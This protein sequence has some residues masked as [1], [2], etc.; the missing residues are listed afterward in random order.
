MAEKQK[1]DRRTFLTGAGAAAMAFT[2]AKPEIAKGYKANEKISLGL[3]GCGGRGGWIAKLFKENGGYDVTACAD[4]FQDRVDVVGKDLNIAAGKRYTGLN[5]YKKL[6]EQ[7][8]DAVAII[9]PPYFHPVQA[10]AAVDAGKHVYVAK[11]IA[12]DVP[13]CNSIEES[14]AKAAGKKRCFLVDFQ[15]RVDQYYIEAVKRVHAGALGEMSF[16]EGVFHGGSPWG[17]VWPILAKDPLNSENRLRAWGLDKVLS[18]DIITQQSIHTLDVMS[19]IMNE[20]PLSAVGTGGR[21]LN[22]DVGDIWDHFV[23]T[24]QYANNVGIAFSAHQIKGFGTQPN[25]IRNR[26]FGSKGVLETK[27]N[28]QIR[29]LGSGGNSYKGGLSTSIYKVGAAANIAGFQKSIVKGDYTNPTVAPSVRST[30]VSILGRKAAYQGRKV[31]WSELLRDNT[32]LDPKL[33][34]KTLKL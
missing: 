32:V 7:D 16:G 25:G 8:I 9:S 34:T 26:M 5:C 6:I 20:E 15:T 30:L 19:W 12:V 29:I 3:I 4:Y 23:L 13:G 11:P 14:S 10:E 1:I 27:Y 17:R 2:I 21:T 22:P 24:Y 18:G 33:D 31:T 28:G